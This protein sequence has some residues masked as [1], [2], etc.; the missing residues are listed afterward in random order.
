MKAGDHIV[1]A[2]F[3]VLVL[4]GMIF[5]ARRT[6][7]FFSIPPLWAYVVFFVL[8][9]LTVAITGSGIYVTGTSPLQHTLVRA[10]CYS[11]GVL[12]TLLV[13][14]CVEWLVSLP[15]HISN[16]LWQGIAVY[17]VTAGLCIAQS[18]TPWQTQ[19][20]HV[21]VPMPGLSRELVIAQLSDVHIGHFRGRDQLARTVEQTNACNPDIVAITGDLTESQYNLTPEALAPLRD[22]RAPVYFVSGNHDGYANL[23]RL[24]SILSELGVRVLDDTLVDTL[25]I[26]LIGVSH[27]SV[28]GNVVNALLID[29]NRPAVMLHHYPKGAAEAHAR[30]VDLI[31]AGHTHGGQLFPITLI[32]HFAFRYNRGLHRYPEYAPDGNYTYIYTSDGVGTTGPPMR[33]GTRSEISIIHL[34]P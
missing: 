1:T 6:A 5:V 17:A 29:R 9:S 11:I 34:K 32:N 18:V 27:S 28:A 12:L 20:K 16:H 15:F 23:L 2:L 7:L 4:L 13:V 8:L 24:K 31:L 33:L 14:I 10:G 30:G 21:V 22:L 26:Q 3:F 25:G 19:V